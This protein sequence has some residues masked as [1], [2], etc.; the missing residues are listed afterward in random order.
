MFMRPFEDDASPKPITL[1]DS[2]ADQFCGACQSK[3]NKIITE[4]KKI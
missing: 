1:L 4:K 2:L 3:L